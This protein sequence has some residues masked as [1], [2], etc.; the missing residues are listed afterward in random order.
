MPLS[1]DLPRYIAA[2]PRYDTVLPE[3]VKFLLERRDRAQKF[4][5]VDVGANIGDT[6]RLVSAGTGDANVSF[7]C[8]EPDEAYLPFLCSN[9]AGLPVVVHNVIAAASTGAANVAFSRIAGTSSV[10]K[11]P[12]ARRTVALDD[13]LSD[14]SIDLIKI[15]TDGYEAEVLRGLARTLD[16]SAPLVFIEFSPRHLRRIGKIEPRDVLG[17][18]VSK[19]YEYGVVYDKFGYPMGLTKLTDQA[20]RYIVNYCFAVPGFY[21][22]ILVWNKPEL[23]SQFYDW[24]F[25]R[26]EPWYLKLPIEA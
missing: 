5:F 7:I 24:D 10:M 23:L 6:V 14:I 8:I 9:T 22:D 15:D 11:G 3:L 25:P 16:R 18:L 1:H 2:A 20:I 12:E 19:G 13:L 4:V 17:Q 21:M 26:Y